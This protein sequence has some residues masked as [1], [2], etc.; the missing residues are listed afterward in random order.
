MPRLKKQRNHLYMASIH[1]AKNNKQKIEVH[2]VHEFESSS[3]CSKNESQ[4]ESKNEVEDDDMIARNIE[5][6][7][8]LVLTNESNRSVR[9]LGNSSRTQNPKKAVL[10]DATRGTKPLTEYWTMTPMLTEAGAEVDVDNGNDA[11]LD[12][13]FD[14]DEGTGWTKA[15]ISLAVENLKIN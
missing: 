1:A 14:E 2:D 5:R 7:F 9:Y 8:V 4:M 12:D 3:A 15:D 6:A 11:D 10:K 13:G